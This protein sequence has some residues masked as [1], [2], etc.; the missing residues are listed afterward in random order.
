MCRKRTSLSDKFNLMQ[1]QISFLAK[2]IFR[3]SRLSLSFLITVIFS[4]IKNSYF[5]ENFSVYLKLPIFLIIPSLRDL[6]Y[7]NLAHFTL[8]NL[9]Q[10]T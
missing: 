10:P 4:G 7:C 9:K 1:L 2:Y 6:V 5:N 8:S 3:V